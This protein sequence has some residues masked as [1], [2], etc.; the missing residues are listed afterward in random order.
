VDPTSYETVEYG[1][2]LL[3]WTRCRQ[4]RAND[5][6]F[7]Y[8]RIVSTFIPRF[9]WPTKP[10]Y[11]RSELGGCLD[12]RL[13]GWSAMKTSLAPPLGSWAQP[14]LNGG[15]IATAIVLGAVALLLSTAYRY[16]RQYEAVP[17]A[18]F[19]WIDHVLQ[20]LAHGRRRRSI[21]LVLLQ[22][23]IFDIPH[24]RRHVGGQAGCLSGRLARPS[25]RPLA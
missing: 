7:N 25:R 19:W 16:F 13:G 6:G 24:C 23:G 20:R 18:Q 21:C 9:I 14:S 15:A 17:W 11:G 8:F 4:S 1:G 3:R 5:F 10:I 12:R 22:L 2:F